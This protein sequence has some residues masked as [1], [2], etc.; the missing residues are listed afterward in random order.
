MSRPTAKTVTFGEG[1]TYT[2]DQ[3]GFLDQPEQWDEDPDPPH[4]PD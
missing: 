2:L 4:S 3:Y 1:K